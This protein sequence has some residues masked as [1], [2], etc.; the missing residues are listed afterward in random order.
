MLLRYVGSPDLPDPAAD[1]NGQSG[2]T[3]GYAQLRRP[4]LG[5]SARLVMRSRRRSLR[6][7]FR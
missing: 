5:Y 4:H 1:G 3:C 6:L 7:K 2:G